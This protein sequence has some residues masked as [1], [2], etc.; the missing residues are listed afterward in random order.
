M[1]ALSP[2]NAA[3]RKY[4]IIE[5]NKLLDQTPF[6]KNGFA[7][8]P[9]SLSLDLDVSGLRRAMVEVSQIFAQAGWITR[10]GKNLEHGLI[11]VFYYP[12]PGCSLN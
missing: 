9:K 6:D 2:E 8:V 5:I 3:L 10:C 12:L 11:I 7:F 4:L 1:L